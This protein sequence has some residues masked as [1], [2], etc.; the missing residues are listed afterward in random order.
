MNNN[1]NIKK[2][3]WLTVRCAI[4]RKKIKALLEIFKSVDN[5]YEADFNKFK[6][7]KFL[8]DEER[9]KLANKTMN[10]IDDFI[11][12]LSDNQVKIVTSDN[13]E[14][15][16][17]LLKQTYDYPYVLYCRGKFVNLNNFTCVAMVGARKATEYGLNCAKNLAY[18]IAKSGIIIVSG[19]A[20][21]IDTAAHKGA[22][23]ARGITV[24]VLGCGINRV[25]PQSNAS[26]M[27]K[28]M[29]TGMVIS[30]YPPNT[31]PL[32]HHFPERNRII[33]GICRGTV[34]VEAAFDSGSLITANI[35]NETNRDVFA[36]PGNINSLYSKGTNSLIKECA[37]VV[38]EADD[39]LCH[40]TDNRKKSSFDKENISDNK[41]EEFSDKEK[42][43]LSVL[44]GE[45]VHID[46]ILELTNLD[47]SE[48]SEI[49]LM[50][51][52][53]EK[54]YS[55]AGNMYALSI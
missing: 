55:T 48:L 53:D 37:Y 25:Y 39:I 1:N 10:G 14:E 52:V 43:V 34:V 22:L 31:E 24:A 15:Y 18:D 9:E 6:P 21:G 11:K 27:K 20:Y 28:I 35:A 50:L 36:V 2:W 40:Y 19:M 33:S 42:L 17:H 29:E 38:T 41:N 44:G 13:E 54:I 23:E 32:K 49:L 7:F 3:L 16:P 12:T 51:E 47:F 4:S 5:I 8:T 45:P 26:L 30:E 46:K